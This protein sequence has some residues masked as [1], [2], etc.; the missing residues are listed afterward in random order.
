MLSFGRFTTRFFLVVLIL[1]YVVI[2]SFLFF[3]RFIILATFLDA[4]FLAIC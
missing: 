2:D 3:I 4:A 1:I